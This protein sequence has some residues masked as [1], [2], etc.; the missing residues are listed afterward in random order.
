MKAAKLPTLIFFIAISSLLLITSAFA[1]S[2]SKLSNIFTL[3]TRTEDFPPIEGWQILTDKGDTYNEDLLIDRHGKAWCFYFRSPGA[4]QPVYLKIFSPSGYLYKIE[5]IVGYGSDS[6]LPQYNSIRA[7]ENDSTGDVWVAIQGNDGGYFVIFD[8]TGAVQQDSTVLSKTAF[9]P[10]VA[11]G[12]N[13]RMWFSWHTQIEPNSQSMGKIACYNDFGEP[14]FTPINIGEHFYLINTDLAVDDSNR[15]WTV[16]ES[17]QGGEY[18]TRFAIFNT[19]LSLYQDGMVVN[20][21][22]LPLN[23][24]RQIFSDRINQRIWILGKHTTVNQQ[25][26]HLYS[27]NG[28]QLNTIENI[29]DCSF[30]KNE[31]DFLEVIR[32]NSQN[33]NNKTY[34]VSLYNILN[35]NFIES[36]TKFEDTH[37]FVRNGIA[38]NSKYPTLKLFSVQFD[39]NLT[40]LKFETV[41]HRYPIIAVKAIQ[42]DTT[43][44]S[45]TYRKQRIVGVR[46]D[47]DAELVVTNVVPQDQ[48]FTVDQTSFTV[49]PGE[50]HNINVYF[51]PSHTDTIV[52]QILFVSND[53]HQDSLKVTVTGRGYEPTTPIITVTPDSLIFDTITLGNAQTKFLY[54]Y[55]EDNY[56]PLH[57]QSIQSSNR[58]FTTSDSLG[59]TLKAKESRWVPIIFR[60]ADV[61]ETEGELTIISNDPERPELHVYARGTGIRYGTPVIAVTPDSLDF[62]EIAIGHQRSLYLEITNQGN[63]QLHIRNI[64]A[65]DSQFTASM[66]N[67]YIPA[68]SRY[69]VLITYHAMRLGEVTSTVTIESS[70]NAMP[71]YE[72]KV[73]GSARNSLPAIISISPDSLHF[74]ETAIGTAKTAYFWISNLGEEPLSIENISSD[75]DRFNVY[76][77]TL[78]V[79]P[80]YPKA[81]GTT[82][83]P[84]VAGK[85]SGLLT[86]LSNDS[87]NEA[88]HVKLTGTG[89][90]LTPP[91][92]VVSPRSIDFGSAATTGSL[93]KAFTIYNEGEMPL[94]VTKI[95]LAPANTS[96]SIYP[97]SFTVYYNQYRTVYVTFS[98]K[99]VGQIPGNINITSNAP[100]TQSVSL[101][102]TGRDPLPQQI[103][104][105]HTFMDFDSVALSKSSSKYFYI[106]NTGEK[107]L[108]VN[109][110]TTQDSSFSLNLSRL[111]LNPGQ[112][113]YVLLNF[114]PTAVKNYQDVVTIDSDDP[115]ERYKYINLRG[116]GRL[117][118]DQNIL[119]SSKTLAFDA[120]PIT[121]QRELGLTIYNTGEQALNISLI[122]NA[123]KAFMMQ[124]RQLVVSP[125]SHATVYVTFTPESLKAYQ[126]TLKISSNDPDSPLMQVA[127][128]GTGRNLM[129][130]KIAVYPDSLS[131]GSVGVGLTTTQNIQIQNSGEK[132]LKVD[133]IK[134]NSN[135]F[136]I[137]ENQKFEI[138]PGYSN[139]TSISF[140]PDSVGQFAGQATIYNNDPATPQLKL[141]LAGSGRQVQDPQITFNPD[142]LD[143]QDVA[144]GRSKTVQLYVGNTGEKDLIVSNIVTNDEQFQVQPTSFT[145]NPGRSQA[146]NVTFQPSREDTAKAQLNIM[147][148]D[149]DSSLAIVPMTG[150]GRALREPTLIYYPGE[151]IFGDVTVDSSVSRILTVENSGD[152]GLYLYKTLSLDSHFVADTDTALIPG[153]QKIN[154]TVTFTP[155]D[156]SNYNSSLIIRSNDPTNY[157]IAVPL[158]G[159]GKDR[160]QQIVISPPS[161]DFKEV[162]IYNTATNYL[163]ISNLGAQPLTIS[164]IVSSNPHFTA[165]TTYFTLEQNQNRQVPVRFQP[166][167][168]KTFTG[169]LT[170][171]SDDPVAGSLVV[172]VSGTGRDSLAQKIAVSSDSLYFGRVAIN[173]TSVLYVNVTNTGEKALNI[174]NISTRSDFFSSNLRNFRLLPGTSQ[175]LSIS[176][177]PT[178]A[179][180]YSDSLKIQSDDPTRG[181]LFVKLRGIG[182]E[183]LPQKIAVSDTLLQ[184]GTVPTDRTKSLMLVIS[185]PGEKNLEISEFTVNNNQFSVDQKWLIIKPGQQHYV[186][187]TFSPTSSGAVSANL[188]IKCNDPTKPEFKVR[189]T[190][191]GVVYTGPQITI[192]SSSIYFSNTLVGVTKSLSLWIVNSSKVDTLKITQFANTNQAFAITPSKLNI[193]PGDSGA[194]Q[195]LFTPQYPGN[196]TTKITIYSNDKYQATLD[197]WVYGNAIEENIGENYLTSLGWRTDGFTPVGDYFS[198]NPHTDSLL[199]SAPDRAWFIKDVILLEQASTAVMNLCF[200]DQIQL[201]INGNLVTEGESAQP[202]YWNVINVNVKKY[203]KFGRN[204]IAI[205]VWNLYDLGG[206]DCELIVN[207]LTK[208]KRGDQNWTHP[209]A[210]WFRFGTMGQVYPNP[211]A[212]GPLNRLWFHPEYGLAGVD[213]ITANWVFEP[214]G[215]D[216]LFD[217][218]PYGQ[219]AV[220][221]NISWIPGVIGQAMEFGGV[222]NSYVELFTNFNRV[223]QT[224][225]LWF[226]C[227]GQRQ[228][229]QNLIS[230]KGSAAYGQGLFISPNMRLGVYYYNGEYITN[231]VVI[232]NTWYF[233][234]T[235]YK[236]NQ[237]LVHVNNVL[238]ETIDYTQGNPIGSAICYLGSNPEVQ[239]LTAFHGAID[240]LQ[241]KS[242]ET[243][244]T[245]MQEVATIAVLPTQQAEK[246]K[247]FQIGFDIYPT[248]FKILSGGVDFALG[249]SDE[250]ISQ[251]FDNPDSTYTTPLLVSIPDDLLTIRGLK[252]RV[253][254]QTNY[255][256][257]EYP[258]YDQFDNDFGWIDVTTDG[259]TRPEPFPQKVHHMI[260]VPYELDDTEIE[261]VLENSLGSVNPYKWRL[262]KW[263]EAENMYQ[264]LD[265]STWQ[266]QYSFT[267]GEAFWLITSDS[268]RL[269]GGPGHSPANE[270]F[271]ITLQPGWN[272]VGNPFPYPINC[273]DIET[274]SELIS[275]PIYRETADSI[276]W[277]YNVESILP[278]QGYFVWN[279]D[280]LDRSLIVPPRERSEIALRKTNSLSNKYLANCQGLS[281]L[282]SADLRCGKFVDRDNLF[283]AAEGAHDQYDQFDLKEAPAIGDYVSLWVD[284]YE[285]DSKPGAYTIDIRKSGSD[286]YVWN[287]VVDYSIEKPADFITLK[288]MQQTALPQNWL[289]YLFDLDDDIAM[290]LGTQKDVSFKP[291]ANAATRKKY[292]L[293]VGS[294][295]F[296]LQNSENIPLVPLD[297][298]LFQNY[299][300]P[301]N[302]ATT[303]SFNL[304]KRMEVSVKI[305]NILGQLVKTVVDEEIRAGH[306]KI[307]WDGR[308]NHGN[309]AATG[310]YIIR[311]EAKQNVAVKK[312]LLI[313]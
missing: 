79:Y 4:S 57:V 262:F 248:P 296:V 218:T 3:D 26:L 285:W 220:L 167:S 272:M 44:I 177:T 98:P 293:V 86:I 29:G 124:T 83:S 263:D 213:S 163:W 28:S 102:G 150:L 256:T 269:T 41:T 100:P 289:I 33:I 74:G 312:L 71:I 192:R 303:I 122:S 169:K 184:F 276:G 244:P 104:V 210:T 107:P 8:S 96:F 141:P 127:M 182:K 304:P 207:G 151:L 153:G 128:N 224:V 259:E 52:S 144:V 43:K 160:T 247:A 152:L 1:D 67:F 255:G 134:V 208:I 284:N 222:A 60:P 313:K 125:E 113:Q 275:G 225:E 203:L 56:E 68:F 178:T 286:G 171:F 131:F 137:G 105:S 123:N 78:T 298:E 282:L 133:S 202:L 194:A 142:R 62:G 27:L 39:S 132:L 10:K 82:F 161:L 212:D 6:D 49:A 292:K 159:K 158:Y 193:A 308:N 51:A 22:A 47:G 25:Q 201:F 17:N 273:D 241:I 223:P 209:D 249:G 200:S 48:H 253:V 35:G 205:R 32:F 295:Q 114:A 88:V 77:T 190:G 299:P 58:Q 136:S 198:P 260:S 75:N 14:I 229:S 166:D 254:L 7:A 173:N 231:F 287:L 89:R 36:R 111:T 294:E 42:F 280:S 97:T 155:S 174:Y 170:I 18:F 187:V 70:D 37:E 239:D 54:V 307:L 69:Y 118:R 115:K 270:P 268:V 146:L 186:N 164:N 106:K 245:P 301:F 34:D 264:A 109:S 130:Q 64:S 266:N 277:V 65:A 31:R 221:H 197:F 278:G 165:Q 215:S 119:L 179:I 251:Q 95:E 279:G 206:F 238:V 309:L 219:R 195:I 85:D 235:M 228:Y 149:P 53:P 116:I 283:G 11:P 72:V 257:I 175:T 40:K 145:V 290:N 267:R 243:V 252:Y 15:V 59:F 99:Q 38:Y 162:R 5:Q 227:Y 216:T 157:H 93:T 143:F 181:V 121:M 265:D 73:N 66:T 46:N 148:N 140:S 302:A 204:R 101:Q 297:F 288:F 91:Q 129:N 108:V 250:F 139:W 117:L 24:Q 138:Q 261:T 217:G 271:R 232:P 154:I 240:E 176:F 16:F 63:S 21:N 80:G 19:D 147:S 305:Y 120:V 306:H 61:G 13:G 258:D 185:N 112:S 234:S 199:S 81:V 87:E 55:N 103:N 233:V 126:D 172:P 236:S 242:T 23:T 94:D 183:P 310:V 2:R 226:N 84:T 110:I 311:L 196:H 237:I 274:T 180:N 12:R 45:Q 30:T 214:T 90:T 135:Y 211:P 188:T 189:L 92:M 156:T 168:L 50:S 9:L 291:Y 20:R 246:G 191:T 230:N 300:N 281:L 76:Q